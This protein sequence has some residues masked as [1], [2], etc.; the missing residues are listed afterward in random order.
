MDLDK[1]ILIKGNKTY[2][3]EACVFVPK[4][5]NSL[6]TKANNL[7]GDYPIGV[8]YFKESDK[9]KS[10]Y[11]TMDGKE[12]HLGLFDTPEEAFISYKNAKEKYIKQIAEEYKSKIP[13][14]LYKAMINYE[15][16]ITD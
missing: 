12:I 15:V 1:D 10:Q 4:K 2:S 9:F 11:K 13:Q 5:I 7:R 16:E 14:K 3:P 8:S 6:F